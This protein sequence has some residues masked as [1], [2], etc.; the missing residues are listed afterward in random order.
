MGEEVPYP[1]GIG[2]DRDVAIEVQI[3]IPEPWFPM[4]VWIATLPLPYDDP[5]PI[6]VFPVYAFSGLDLSITWIRD[7]GAG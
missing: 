1:Y 7:L 6:R 3:S 4:Q 5:S 2:P